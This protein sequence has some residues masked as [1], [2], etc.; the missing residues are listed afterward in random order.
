MCS[1]PGHEKA[2][3]STTEL[4]ACNLGYA[5]ACPRLPMERAADAVRF[6]VTKQS[7]DTITVQ[8][9]LET[10][11]LP[12]GHGWLEY[13]RRLAVWISPHAEPRIQKLAESFL[14]SYLDRKSSS[15]NATQ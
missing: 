8:F 6:S 7:G 5:H 9:V 4:E 11:Y 2:I 12:A 15:L 3:L 1:A 10:D 13:D 14:Q